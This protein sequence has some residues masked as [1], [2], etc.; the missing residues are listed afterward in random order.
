MLYL[1]DTGL[2]LQIG[3]FPNDLG[4]IDAWTRDC[5]DRND[6]ENQDD[7]LPGDRPASGRQKDP[8]RRIK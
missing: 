2:F 1:L 5:L 7:Q 8:L 4:A 3:L 6:P